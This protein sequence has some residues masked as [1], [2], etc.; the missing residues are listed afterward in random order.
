MTSDAGIYSGQTMVGINHAGS[1]HL[2]AQDVDAIKFISSS[3]NIETGE[4][5]MYGVVNA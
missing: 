1:M 2:V 5:V 4:I 3:G